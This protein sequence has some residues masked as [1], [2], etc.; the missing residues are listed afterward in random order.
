VRTGKTQSFF[1]GRQ[2]PREHLARQALKAQLVPFGFLTMLKTVRREYRGVPG[3]QVL[4]GQQERLGH[5]AQLV[6]SGFQMMR[7]TVRQ[8]CQG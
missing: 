3:R 4:L 6:L 8:E 5:R 7:K 1:L 2:G